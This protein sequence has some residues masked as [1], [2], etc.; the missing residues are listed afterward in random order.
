MRLDYLT[1]EDEPKSGAR[2][3]ELPP[4][5]ATEELRKDLL[6]VSSGNAEPFV[7]HPDPGLVADRRGGHLDFSSVRRIF[8]RVRKKVPNHLGKAVAIATDGEALLGR[9]KLELV[10]VALGGVERDLG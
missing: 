10:R 4:H 7:S 1:R 8:D 9:L 6:L 5:V 3:P 2:D